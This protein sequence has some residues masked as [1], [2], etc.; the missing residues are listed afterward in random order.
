MREQTSQ[1]CDACRLRKAKCQTQA[2]E[3]TT[4]QEAQ[5]SGIGTLAE[6]PDATEQATPCQ[7]CTKMGIPCTYDMPVQRRGPKGP[8]KRKLSG[9]E[10]AAAKAPTEKIESGSPDPA[11]SAQRIALK[12]SHTATSTDSP[13]ISGVQS[14]E[15]YSPTWI[16]TP[17][18][19][20]HS[21]QHHDRSHSATLPLSHGH[22]LSAMSPNWSSS[23]ARCVTDGLCDRETLRQIMDDYIVYIYPAIPIFHLPSFRA[24]FDAQ[25]DTHDA[26]FF[27]LLMGLVS[28]TVGI[29]TPKFRDYQRAPRPI[30]FLSR[31]E[32]IDYCYAQTVQSRT[33]SYF[34]EV[35][36]TKWAISHTFYLAYFHV[37]KFNLSRM[38]ELECNLFARLLELHRPS[39]LVGLNCIETQLR[40][41]AF[42]LM[43]YAYVH[44]QYSNL[45]KER[46]AFIDCAILHELDLESLLPMPHDDDQISDTTYGSPPSPS[47]PSLAEGFNWRSR[48]F[49]AG[50]KSINQDRQSRRDSMHCHCTRRKDLPVYLDFLHARLRE[51]NYLLDGAPWYLRQWATKPDPSRDRAQKSDISSLQ[52]EVIRTDIHVSHVWLQSI[53]MDH[54]ESYH[55]IQAPPQSLPLPS[56]LSPPTPDTAAAMQLSA[57][58]DWAQREDLCR[59]LLQVLYMAPD[60][61]LEALG[62]VLVHKVRDVAVSLLNCPYDETGTTASAATTSAVTSGP[63]TRAKAYL[64]D[65]SRKLNELDMTEGMSSH[66]LQSWVDTGKTTNGRYDHW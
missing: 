45:R 22:P 23:S 61:S 21:G 43:F 12:R 7:R 6:A 28:L 18:S 31:V 47:T 50:V 4:S 46:M 27:G 58:I 14:S 19:D 20:G 26:A 65:F 49:W 17:G 56:A 35:S 48:L 5:I 44:F 33:A 51:L 30:R 1:A 24:A 63:A 25:R 60:L 40:K 41:R 53:L 29:L 59:Q 10:G 55:P 52:M 54:I 15:R 38:I 39:A 2:A 16:R 66:I 37:G 13:T 34:D 36:H 64:A 32:M 9:E 57:K 62:V 3:E 42:W 11:P 8:R